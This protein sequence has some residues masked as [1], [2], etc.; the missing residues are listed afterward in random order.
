MA[1]SPGSPQKH[2]AL[3]RPTPSPRTAPNLA[4]RY[5]YVTPT[6]Y[7]ELLGTFIKLLGEKRTEIHNGRH[8]WLGLGLCGGG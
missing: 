2:H 7:L 8:R 1:A 4:R 5:N 6:S 3:P